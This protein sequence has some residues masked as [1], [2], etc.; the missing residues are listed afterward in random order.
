MQQ[1]IT[2]TF[3]ALILSCFMLM[4]VGYLEAKNSEKE[5]TRTNLAPNTLTFNLVNSNVSGDSGKEITAKLRINCYGSESGASAY[6]INVDSAP[7][8]GYQSATPET[9]SLYAGDVVNVD[10]KFKRTVSSTT[11]SVYKFR[12]DWN[13]NKGNFKTKNITINVTYKANNTDSDSDNDGI[14]DSR[15][16]CPNTRGPASNNGCPIVTDPTECNR[17][18]P[19]R[20]KWTFRSDVAFI[21]EWTN[22][23]A[24]SYKVIVKDKRGAIVLSTFSNSNGYSIKN[25]TPNTNYTVEVSTKCT[26][27]TWG[28]PIK[29]AFKTNEGCKLPAP[30]Y[31]FATYN[32]VSRFITINWG[33]VEG[34]YDYWLTYKNTK[35]NKVNYKYLIFDDAQ[36]I[37]KGLPSNTR[38]E[39]TIVARCIDTY[40]G[41]SKA[42]SFTTGANSR[43]S[44]GVSLKTSKLTSNEVSSN[45]DVETI[46]IYPN[47]ASDILNIDFYNGQVKS[48]VV[49]NS[50]GQTV[51]QE[52]QHPV[53]T[54][55]L[56]VSNFTNGLYFINLQLHNGETIIKKFY[57]E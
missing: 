44:N 43:T 49:N 7:D 18:A 5:T 8:N 19:T 36:V 42:F 24:F 14:P 9:K 32:R 22:M 23:N 13:D 29:Y 28:A 48:W 16:Q 10:F 4:S 46:N 52:V 34:A 45:T 47:P 41:K 25:L 21:I 33:R 26:P 56:N 20:I 38:Y 15:D 39:A 37:I 50:L 57:K 55:Q 6:F 1:R 12:I 11:T 31:A 30:L 3:K 2:K 27:K 53:E 40:Q 51:F 17:A 35:T 54:S